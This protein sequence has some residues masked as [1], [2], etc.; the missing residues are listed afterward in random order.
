MG[1]RR[2]EEDVGERIA[3]ELDEKGEQGDPSLVILSITSNI[4]PLSLRES[5][6]KEEEK[7]GE[8]ERERERLR[9]MTSFDE[10]RI[11]RE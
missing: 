7:G 5:Q 4:S 1:G 6:E 8:R 10:G 9:K 11:W 2:G 3:M